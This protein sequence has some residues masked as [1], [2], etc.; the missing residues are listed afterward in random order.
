MTNEEYI[1]HN[2][3]EDDIVAILL[4][5]G[6]ACSIVVE[7]ARK[8]FQC[9]STFDYTRNGNYGEDKVIFLF[10]ILNGFVAH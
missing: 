3:T 1:K 9:W 8:V 4:D 2:L 7:K 10:G 6:G 5:R